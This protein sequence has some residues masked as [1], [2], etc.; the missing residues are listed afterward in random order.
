MQ[1][2]LW[3]LIILSSIHWMVALRTEHLTVTYIDELESEG[4]ATSVAKD[5][6]GKSR[7][8]AADLLKRH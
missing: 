7:T 6:Q 8:P 1:I 3:L 4:T 5:P 2:L